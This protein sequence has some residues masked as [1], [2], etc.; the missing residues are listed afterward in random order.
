L[1]G[2]EAS[3]TLALDAFRQAATSLEDPLV[4]SDEPPP[5]PAITTAVART[6]RRPPPN[7]YLE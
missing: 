1:S 7:A 4:E 3:A 5:Q 2:F 6:S